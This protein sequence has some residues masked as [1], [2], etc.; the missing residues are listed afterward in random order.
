MPRLVTNEAVLRAY[1]PNAF[2]T[3]DDEQSL[4]SKLK[5]YLDSSEKWWEE[6]LLGA[7]LFTLLSRNDNHPIY[8]DVVAAVVAEAFATA[9]PALDLVLTPNGFGVVSNQNVAPASPARVERLI[10]SLKDRRDSLLCH[11]LRNLRRLEEWRQSLQCDWLALSLVQHPEDAYLHRTEVKKLH[12]IW[13]QFIALREKTAPF[14][15]EIANGWLSPELYGRICRNMAQGCGDK[16][17]IVLRSK[18][19][20][21][22]FNACRSGALS[23]SALADVVNYIRNN[24]EAFPEWE[25]SD[26]AKLFSPTTF[27][28]VKQAGGYFF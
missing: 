7:E 6:N 27:E 3:V 16:A 8:A 20:T 1:I 13:L 24:P 9:I 23:Q 5:A 21:I 14:E 26:T 4:F 18:V 22:I 28:N 11:V 19:R 17:S 10:A 12:D 15:Q 2:A 25:A